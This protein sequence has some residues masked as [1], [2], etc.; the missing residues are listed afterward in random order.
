MRRMV[1]DFDKDYRTCSL[2][3]A[4]A[5]L[6][7]TEKIIRQNGTRE[8]QSIEVFSPSCRVQAGNIFE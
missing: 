2:K 6:G 7:G 8:I 3:V 1:I 5:K 4:F